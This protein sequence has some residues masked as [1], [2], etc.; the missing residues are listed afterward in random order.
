M[1]RFAR[2]TLKS[3]S[4]TQIERQ[5]IEAQDSTPEE[6]DPYTKEQVEAW[7]TVC[8]SGLPLLSNPGIGGTLTRLGPVLGLD[9]RGRRK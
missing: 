5:A 3:N 2:I 1:V 7:K 9:N 6:L 4:R 8:D